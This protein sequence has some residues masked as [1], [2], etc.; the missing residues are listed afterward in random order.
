MGYLHKQAN[1]D[2]NDKE[3]SDYFLMYG[4]TVHDTVAMGGGF[5]D[6]VVAIPCIG[7]AVNV[8]VEIKNPIN[9]TRTGK[10]STKQEEFFLN[11]LG[12]CEE[13]RTLEDVQRII[14]K[15]KLIDMRMVV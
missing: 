5:P 11:W 7:G 15:Y 9:T 2:A 12:P 14:K 3:I 6:K 1:R 4:C 8:L 13:A 10:L